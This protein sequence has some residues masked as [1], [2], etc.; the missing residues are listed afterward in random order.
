L[1]FNGVL[2]KIKID[3]A[4]KEWALRIIPRLRGDIA[5]FGL[6]GFHGAEVI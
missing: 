4:L 6:V 2:I 1:G 3:A 5:T